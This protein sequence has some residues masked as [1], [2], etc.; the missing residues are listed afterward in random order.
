MFLQT[1]G[2]LDTTRL[3]NEFF[4]LYYGMTEDEEVREDVEVFVASQH[5]N[6]SSYNPCGDDIPFHLLYNDDDLQED[7]EC[8]DET[9]R[10]D[11]G[12]VVLRGIVQVISADFREAVAAKFFRRPKPKR[13][14][15]YGRQFTHRIHQPNKPP[16]DIEREVPTPRKKYSMLKYPASVVNNL[17]T[18][19]KNKIPPAQGI[20]AAGLE[21]NNSTRGHWARMKYVCMM[22][23][24][25]AYQLQR[26]F[27]APHK[28]DTSLCSLG[29]D[30]T[31]GDIL[32]S[33]GKTL[34]D[35]LELA[36]NEKDGDKEA[37]IPTDEDMRLFVC[38]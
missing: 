24:Q 26:L 32:N 14:A 12:E 18:A 30:A 36:D 35:A 25:E 22:M 13:S 31:V 33:M 4:G 19:L 15:R 27:I 28:G 38:V 9:A 11:A 3:L 7:D 10:D 37:W 21:Y 20:R 5:H 1:D 17:A 2:S 8:K 34:K 16:I 29:S 6:F 23:V